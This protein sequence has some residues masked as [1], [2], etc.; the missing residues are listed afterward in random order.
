M[1]TAN[2]DNPTI[3]YPDWFKWGD[4]LKFQH[5]RGVVGYYGE[6]LAYQL[7]GRDLAELTIYL[8][9]QLLWD[10][11]RNA[12]ELRAH[13]L[14]NYY[15]AAA[16]HILTYMTAMVDSMHAVGMC[17]ATGGDGGE[18]Y[19]ATA[20]FLT[21]SAMLA[22]ARAFADARAAVL[23][24]PAELGRVDRAKM[25]LYFVVLLRWAEM[26]AYAQSSGETWPMEA[27]VDQA[28]QE[29][30]RVANDTA[31]VLR[32][33][34]AENYPAAETGR[35]LPAAFGSPKGTTTASGTIP[36]LSWLKQQIHN[37]SATAWCQPGYVRVIARSS[38]SFALI[39]FSSCVGG[40]WQNAGPSPACWQNCS[41]EFACGKDGAGGTCDSDAYCRGDTPPRRRQL[42]GTVGS[43]GTLRR[44]K[45][46]DMDPPVAAVAQPPALLRSYSISL[47]QNATPAE[48][49]AAG[50]LAQLCGN[51]SNGNQPLPLV[52][53]DAAVDSGAVLAVGSGAS[54]AAGL[55]VGLLDGL[56]E[57]GFVVTAT[58]LR[59]GCLAMTGGTGRFSR[60]ALFAVYHFLEALGYRTVAW[61]ET[62]LPPDSPHAQVMMPPASSIQVRAAGAPSGFVWRE[63]D[64]WPV[65]N[66]AVFGRRMRL[67]GGN[68][69]FDCVYNVPGKCAGGFQQQFDLLR[70]A[71][72]PGMCHTAY[73]MLC[74]NAT[75]DDARGTCPR[76]DVP[77]QD[78][79]RTHN[80][81]FW[82]HNCSDPTQ[83]QNSDNQIINQAN[84]SYGQLCWH[85]DDLIKHLI[86][87][88]RAMLTAAKFQPG[89]PV[90]F[91]SVTQNE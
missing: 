18:G 35:C 31:S 36:Y 25:G 40:F 20:A 80:H 45:A 2:Y 24:Q 52:T 12:T 28:F 27:T 16:P 76:F 63:V 64:D 9:S 84:S 62:L 19:P 34:F 47:A 1:Q 91:F 51:I 41:R 14:S 69:Y 39:V 79:F 86:N 30:S 54:V 46:R 55:S 42:G 89:P 3:P 65:Y 29:Y 13:F 87:Q 17:R 88:A 21:P 8:Q 56:G 6:G 53:P 61:D 67:N 85:N 33:Y 37:K 59:S 90:K 78:L 71:D 60:G 10:V 74:A 15:G 58:G 7:P 81:W 48:Q 4:N 32:C 50:E 75:H 72:P 57:E 82:P 66:S 70:W 11:G 73:K 38:C 23:D 68:G 49:F 5:E 44:L 43:Y 26:R 77:P 83:C 22:G